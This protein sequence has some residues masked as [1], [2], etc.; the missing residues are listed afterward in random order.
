VENRAK[1]APIQRFRKL[2]DWELLLLHILYFT[3][4]KSWLKESGGAT[5]VLEV[6]LSKSGKFFC[7]TLM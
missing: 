4:R 6:L 1:Y 5:I 7:E 2:I 3:D